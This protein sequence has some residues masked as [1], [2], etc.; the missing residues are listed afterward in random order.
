MVMPGDHPWVDASEAPLFVVRFPKDMPP[1]MFES[2]ITAMETHTLSQRRPF[3]WVAALDPLMFVS[4]R[5]R[6]LFAE[7]EHR[8]ASHDAEYCAGVALVLPS[9]ITRGIVKSLYWLAPPVYPYAISGHEHEA[10]AWARARLRAADVS[11]VP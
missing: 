1:G 4:T 11:S 10:L 8:V 5:E 2:C 3:V 9:P 6:R 7:Y